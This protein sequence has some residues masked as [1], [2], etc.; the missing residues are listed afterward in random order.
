MSI[1][2]FL[3]HFSLKA[4]YKHSFSHINTLYLLPNSNHVLLKYVRH[5]QCRQNEL[6]TKKKRET[7]QGLLTRRASI[8]K[9]YISYLVLM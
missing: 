9:K 8:N 2:I 4:L 5:R 1:N 3:F 6:L 7:T